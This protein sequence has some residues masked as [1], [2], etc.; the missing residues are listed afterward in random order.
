MQQ[1]V[2]RNPKK[3]DAWIVLGRE[4]V[5][6][7]RRSADPGFYLNADACATI[8][9]GLEPD[10]NL[11][12]NLRA[13]V[14][15]NDHKF[16]QAKELAMDMVARDAQD[17]MAWGS[18]SDAA[19]E[20]GQIDVASEAV[21]KMLDLKPNLPSYSRAGYLRWLEGDM[22][23]AKDAMRLA[24]DA[25]RGHRDK[26]PSAW[27]LVEAANLF[28][29]EG[30]YEAAETGYQTAAA[31]FPGFAPAIAGKGKIALAKKDY[32]AAAKLFEEAFEKS[33]LAATAWLLGDA[34]SAAGDAPGAA[35]A[36]E[37]VEKIGRQA[38]HLVL[39]QFLAAKNRD[40]DE[41]VSEG[42]KLLGSRGGPYTNDAVAWALYRAGKTAEARPFADRAIQHGTRDARLLYHAGA[43]R[44]AS[45]DAS[46]RKLVEEALALNPA[47]DWTE[48]EE[49][50][51]L[52]AAHKDG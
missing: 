7:A 10:S 22:A 13:L 31:Y 29:H 49:A 20:L 21:Q 1:S 26:E 32:A 6:K 50:R 36:Y 3:L 25:G 42:Q 9:L 46:G 35:I 45:G 38:D 28:W 52:L 8:A 12:F 15:L 48:A 2:Q 30:N 39:V 5:R 51:A 47:F 16:Q 34:K 27:A 11:A 40:L 37:Q 44:M 41:A 14:L 24:F 4:W 19:L 23:G 17:A 33:P 43:I 18:L